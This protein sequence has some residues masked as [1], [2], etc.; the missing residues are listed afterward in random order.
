[1]WDDLN[2]RVRGLATHFLTRSQLEALARVPDLPGLVRALRPQGVP[3]AEPM[4]SLRPEDVELGIRR[5]AANAL[6]VLARWAGPRAATLPL[7]FDDEDRRSLRA[8]FRGAVEQVPAERRLAG[9]IPTPALPER[10]LEE[11]ARSPTAAAAA[12]LLAAW[13]HPFAAALAPVVVEAHPDVFALDLTLVRAY[14][15]RA[16]AASRAIRDADVQAVVRELIDLE[17]GL[18]AIVLSIEGTDVVPKQIFLS[19][20]ERVSIVAFEQAVATRDPGTAGA[21]LA[22]ALDGTPYA[23]VFRRGARDPVTL[24]DELLRR[25]LRAIS[26]RVRLAPLGPLPILW[27]GL[28]LR[29]QVVD[30]QRVVWTVA[31]DAPRQ[32]LVDT[33]ATVAT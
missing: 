2:A 16:F 5:W 6:R 27:F 33:L 4:A 18:T 7:I 1:M 12:A 20:G 17:N 31:L 14:A 3:L 10:A 15:D 30:L 23:E 26:R 21:R 13:R 22:V 29:V 32:R 25:R 24:E 9:L 28:R 19:G 11:L 8:I